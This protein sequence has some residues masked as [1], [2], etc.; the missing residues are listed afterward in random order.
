MPVPL[1]L[2]AKVIRKVNFKGGLCQPKNGSVVQHLVCWAAGG[3]II[4]LTTSSLD[5][6]KARQQ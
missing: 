6:A 3:I 2:P 4:L 5:F 1:V